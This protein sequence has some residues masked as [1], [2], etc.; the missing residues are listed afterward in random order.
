MATITST[1]SNMDDSLQYGSVK[2]QVYAGEEALAARTHVR[3]EFKV[4][5]STGDEVGDSG[6]A[7]LN[8][9][10]ALTAQE[11]ATFGALAK[12]VFDY[13]VANSRYVAE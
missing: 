10:P 2:L 8:V 3:A 1:P 5:L 9:H 11:R 7:F 12:K 13:H 4:A 6:G